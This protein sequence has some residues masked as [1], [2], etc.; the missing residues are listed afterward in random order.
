MIAGFPSNSTAARFIRPVHHKLPPPTT[1]LTGL[2][3][4]EPTP[5]Y[6]TLPL[7]APP[8]AQQ[9]VEEH[10]SHPILA[11]LPALPPPTITG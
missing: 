2:P 9:G 5:R 7:P 11:D 3:A 1:T 4:P 6:Q 8:S 10:P